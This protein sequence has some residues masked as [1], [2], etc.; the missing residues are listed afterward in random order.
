[1]RTVLG[2]RRLLIH[3]MLAGIIGVMLALW[4][5]HYT[6]QK[7]QLSSLKSYSDY[8]LEYASRVTTDLKASVAN[9]RRSPYQ[10]C[11]DSDLAY[12]RGL[13][14]QHRYL[15]DIARVEN[16]KLLCSAERGIFA[17]PIL[18]P[19]PT[20]ILKSKA[21]FWSDASDVIGIAYQTDMVQVGNI[22]VMTSPFA[23]DAMRPPTE[24]MSAVILSEGTNYIFRTFGDASDVKEGDFVNIWHPLPSALSYSS[25]SDAGLCVVGTTKDAGIY[26]LPWLEVILIALLGGAG[27]GGLF[28]LLYQALRMRY[29]MLYQF[30]KALQ[31]QEL[32]MVYQPKIYLGRNKIVGVEAL[33]RWHSQQFG[34]VSPEVF[35]E[36]AEKH[37]LMHL[38]TRQVIEKSL[39]DMQHLLQRHPHLTLSINLAIQ[40]LADDSLLP[41]IVSQAQQLKIAPQQLICEITERSAGDHAQLAQVVQH[42]KQM[43]IGISLDD[44]GTGYSNLGWLGHLSASEIKVDKTF[45]QSI[46]TGSIN[47]NMLDAIFGLLQSLDIVRVFEGV[48]TQ[49]Q[50]DYILARC[51]DA[52]VQGWL[53]SKALPVQQLDDYI[54][55]HLSG[56]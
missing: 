6:T 44:F 9:A 41:F 11:S 25:C 21:R 30:K 33:V 24:S 7:T 34:F 16:G 8:A 15:K 43:G 17:K 29:T 23:F 19:K 49:D 37:R 53:Y 56:L 38:L 22:I 48:E 54:E 20:T 35:I 28:S 42:Y 13:L 3:I 26:S 14:W 40:D 1:M 39:Q 31:R 45:T 32:S 55:K 10:Q 36:L 27:V 50:A 51:P 5:T 12:L 2:R 52:V 4:I 46:G 18:L 47:Q